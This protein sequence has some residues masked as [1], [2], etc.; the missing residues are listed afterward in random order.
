[1]AEVKAIRS[2]SRSHTSR[3]AT[4]CTRPAE[5]AIEE[6]SALLGVDEAQIKIASVVDGALNGGR[7][8]LVKDHPLDGDLGVEN[9]LEVP[10]NG[11]ALAVF[12]GGEV[13]LVNF[14]EG[15][16]EFAHDLLTVARHDVDRL[17]VVVDVDAQSSPLLAL[18]RGR[19]VGRTLW[20]VA[21]VANGG[22]DDVVLPEHAL[23]TCR[24]RDRF[25]DY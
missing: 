20:Q 9:F 2:R 21:D 7:G 6:A 16:F 25:H 5:R 19:D 17:E 11:L 23:D 12:V 1:V 8:D 3:I 15:G 18:H 14:F 24:F 13:E 22:L 4:D 10:G